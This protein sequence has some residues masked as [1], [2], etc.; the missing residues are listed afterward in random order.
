MVSHSHLAYVT[1]GKRLPKRNS[2]T[3]KTS[4]ETAKKGTHSHA[5][6]GHVSIAP[7]RSATSAPSV[8]ESVMDDPGGMPGGLEPSAFRVSA[9]TDD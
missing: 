3:A 6:L 1:G 2:E 8:A 7:I 4:F 9:F 5:E